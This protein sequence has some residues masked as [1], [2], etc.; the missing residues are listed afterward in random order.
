MNFI[1]K[2]EEFI[3][4]CEKAAVTVLIF[5]MVALS[6]TQV[7]MRAFFSAGILW[8]D[9]LLRYATMWA[10][11]LGAA[12]ASYYG[13]QF[14]LDMTVK[15]FP[16]K[17]RKICENAAHVFTCAVCLFLLSASLTFIKSEFKFRSTAF[18]IGTFDI[19]AVWL[20]IIIPAGFLLAFFHTAIHIFRKNSCRQL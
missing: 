3:V 17:A 8:A 16:E 9:P 2:T 6:F 5:I 11:F 7:I 12:M 19:P 13:K 1:F 14:A 18:S 15:L 10:G 4:A 20:E